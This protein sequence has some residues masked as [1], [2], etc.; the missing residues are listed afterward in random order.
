MGYYADQ[1]YF[2]LVCGGVGDGGGGNA[3]GVGEEYTRKR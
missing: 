2:L 3:G 1:I